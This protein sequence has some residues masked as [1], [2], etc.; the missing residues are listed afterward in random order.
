VT[1]LRLCLVASCAVLLSAIP[2]AAQESRPGRPYRGLF[3]PEGKN[4]AQ[5]LS[6]SG[7]AGIGYDTDVIAERR[8]RVV[9]V[10]N[11][12]FL[13]TDD[14]F[15][16]FGG[17]I[18]YSDHTNGHDIRA[19]LSSVARN[20]SQFA[21]VSSEQASTDLTW[22]VTRRTTLT[23]YQSAMYQ[24]WGALIL[25][26]TATDPGFG[27]AVAPGRLIPVVNGSYKTYS[28]GGTASEQLSRRSAVTA[29][30]RYDI[31]KFSGLDGDYRSQIGTLTYTHG[32]TQNLQWRAG[33]IQAESRFRGHDT[34]Y[35]QRSLDAGLDYSRY[36]S[37]SRRTRGGFSTG[38]TGVEDR[39][40]TR[41]M[42]TGSAFINR[43]IGRTWNAVAVYTRDVAFFETLRVPYFY[44]GLTVGINGLISRRISL[45][46]SVAGTYGDVSVITA[47]PAANHFATATGAAGLILA[48]SRY[49]GIAADYIVYAYSLDDTSAFWYGLTPSFSRQSVVVTLRA[50]LPLIERGRRPD[51][52]R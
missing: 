40:Y 39:N 34:F 26:P 35:R 24:P 17:G 16:V 30:Y 20:Y 50:W 1:H 6:V 41:Y 22:R 44:D 2:A 32:I 10:G 46:S 42:A 13:R 8:D 9:S 51:A 43:E 23:A 52:T 37:S 19:S 15:S 49:A 7:A 4:A 11:V 25:A 3:G 31:A 38:V 21:T 12:S 29:S 47:R 45:H 33:Y 36:L 14:L 5:V 18:D 27:E 48:I 28:A